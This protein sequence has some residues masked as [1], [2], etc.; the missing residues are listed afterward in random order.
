LG[1]ASIFSYDGFY[2]FVIFVDA[3]TKYI[4]YYLFVAKSDV[5]SVFHRFQAFVEVQFLGKNKSIQTGWGGEYHKLN[6]LFQTIGIHHHLI[7]PYTHEQNRIV[8]RLHWHIVETGLNLLGQCKALLQFWNYMFESSVYLMICMPTLFLH[9]KSPFECFF[10]HTPNYD[11]LRTFGCLFFTF[12]CT[13]HAYKLDF[14]SSSYVILDY[15][16]SHLGYYFLDITSQSIYISH[17]VCFY[18]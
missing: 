16:S 12:L 10:H 8:E 1:P 14:C 9:N 3:H 5:F 6:T 11:F 17:H 18:E 7:C 13:Y 15:R 4:W 2:Y